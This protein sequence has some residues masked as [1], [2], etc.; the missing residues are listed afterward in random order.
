MPAIAGSGVLAAVGAHSSS[1][2]INASNF[3]PSELQNVTSYAGGSVSY[4]A[5]ITPRSP[6]MRPSAGWSSVIATVDPSLYLNV[7]T[8]CPSLS[9]SPAR[10]EL[11]DPLPREESSHVPY[12]TAGLKLISG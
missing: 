9:Q 2:S 10:S 1:S 12:Y 7:M 5:Q 11:C 3:F 8:K 6:A 4:S